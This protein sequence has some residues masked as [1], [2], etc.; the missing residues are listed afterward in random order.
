MKILTFHLKTYTK[1]EERC[2][3]IKLKKIKPGS[4]V[5]IISPSNGL[6]FLFPDN[7]ELGVKKFG[8]DIWF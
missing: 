2:I 1:E 8:R 7:Y 6:P 3:L 5:A 4:R